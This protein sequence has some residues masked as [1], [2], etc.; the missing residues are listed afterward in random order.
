[1]Q[2]SQPFR[3]RYPLPPI[4]S[5]YQLYVPGQMAPRQPLKFYYCLEEG[6]SAIRYNHVTEDLE[7][8]IVLKC[9]RTYLFSNL[10]RL[11]TEGPKS[12]K[13]LVRNFSKE[14]EYFTKKMMEQLNPPPKQQGKKLIDDHKDKKAATIAQ[15]EELGNWKPP[16]ISPANEN[17]KINVGSRKTEQRTLR[18]E[19]QG[20]AQKECKNETQ[21]YLKKK[22]P[23]SYHEKNE[24]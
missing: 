6:H 13:E 12:T 8:I 11:P 24:V 22:I 7:K 5:S 2:N 23:G 4:S 16:Q 17:I 9:G 3:P 14:Q 19:T 18:Q 15:V 20:Q 1:M 21:K 10:Q